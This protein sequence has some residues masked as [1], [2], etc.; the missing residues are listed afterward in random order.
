MW[1]SFITFLQEQKESNK[2]QELEKFN[3]P[4]KKESRMGEVMNLEVEVTSTSAKCTNIIE[5]T[6]TY[7]KNSNMQTHIYFAPSIPQRTSK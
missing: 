7:I 1:L 4:Q 6:W 2:E 3:Y 5:Y